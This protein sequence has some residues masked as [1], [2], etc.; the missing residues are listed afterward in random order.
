[1]KLFKTLSQVTFPNHACFQT[2][3]VHAMEKHGKQ[4]ICLCGCGLHFPPKKPWHFSPFLGQKE[5]ANHIMGPPKAFL[6]VAVPLHRLWQ[7]HSRGPMQL[8]ES[9]PCFASAS[10][11]LLLYKQYKYQKEKPVR[12]TISHYLEISKHYTVSKTNC[13]H[14]QNT[15][16]LYASTRNHH[17]NILLSSIYWAFL[18][19]VNSFLYFFPEIP[20]K[21][22]IIKTQ[23]QTDCWKL[24]ACAFQYKKI[25]SP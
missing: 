16:M 8:L 14:Y 21:R 15:A 5:R 22:N 25:C 9:L 4:P 24:F 6:L 18:S 7:R 3:F 23:V 19:P 12:Q 2:I 17:T 1:M 20:F 13:F 11:I 10:A